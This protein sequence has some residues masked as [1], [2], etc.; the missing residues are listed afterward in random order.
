MGTVF[1]LREFKF[2][3]SI[4]PL[5]VGKEMVWFGS[6]NRTGNKHNE[7]HFNVAVYLITNK[8]VL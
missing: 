6:G 7:A 8:T 2:T 1:E 4:F 5:W 3:F